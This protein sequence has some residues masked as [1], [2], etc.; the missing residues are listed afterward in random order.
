MESFIEDLFMDDN[1][2]DSYKDLLKFKSK[3]Y[4]KYQNSTTFLKSFD[5]IIKKHLLSKY[6]ITK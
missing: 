1:N 3:K 5:S 2:N 6:L 4:C